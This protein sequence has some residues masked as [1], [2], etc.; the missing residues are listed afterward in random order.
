MGYLKAKDS[1]EKDHE[2]PPSL[3]SSKRVPIGNE[4]LATGTDASSILG[5]RFAAS[6]SGQFRSKSKISLKL[7]V[8][9][10]H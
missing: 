5:T 8:T 10:L 7:T 1:D 6:V 2:K 9:A 3:L 4:G